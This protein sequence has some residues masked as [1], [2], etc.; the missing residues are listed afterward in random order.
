M[1]KTNRITF[2]VLLCLSMVGC[3]KEFS[4]SSKYNRP[5]WLAGKI[6]TQIKDQPEFSTFAKCLEITGFDTIIN[7]S[8]SYTVFAPNNTA[9]DTYLKSNQYSSVEDIPVSFLTKIVKYMIVQDS[10][11]K[12]QLESLDVYGWIDSTDLNNNKPRG[13]KR[14]T[15]L[16]EPNQKY[17]VT[18]KKNNNISIVDSANGDWYRMVFNNTRKYVPIFFKKYLD[19]SNLTKA[20]Y[21]F[22]F[23]RP[24]ESDDDIYFAGAKIIGNEIFA[25]NGFIYNVDRVVEPLKNAEEILNTDKDGHSYSEFLDLVHFFP[26]F[27]YNF[28]ETY[29]QPGAAEGKKVDSLFGLSY[30]ILAFDISNEQTKPPLGS[31]G[32]PQ[33]VTIRYHHGMVAPTNQAF[34]N[35]I[36]DYIKIPNGWGKLENAPQH[37]KRII[38]NT[39]MSINSVYPS[40]FERGYY[41]GE[42]DYVPVDPATVIQKEFGSNCTFIGVN[43][44]IIPRAFSSV[45]GPVYT[46]QGYSRVMYAIEN[47][48]LLSALKRKD[49]NYMFL[50]E[51]DRNLAQDSSLIYNSAFQNFF[52]FQISRGTANRFGLTTND[53]RTLL[54]NHIGS[55]LPT[56]NTRKEFI[57]NLAGNYIV[58]NNETG[59]VS[60]TDRTTIGYDGSENQPNFLKK[61]SINADNGNTY[62]ISNWLSFTESSIYSRITSNF[63]YFHNLLKKAGYDDVQNRSY[64]FLSD[65]GFYTV[66]VPTQ[67]AITAYGADTLTGQQLKDFLLLHFIQGKIIFTDGKENPGYYDTMRPDERSTEFSKVFTKIYIDPEPDK[68]LIPDKSGNN[69]LTID[70]SDSTNIIAGKQIGEGT[71]TIKNKITYGVIHQISKV[72]TRNNVNTN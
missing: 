26:E 63:P 70:E 23:D 49:A 51:S 36:N 5:D 44:A 6:Y 43:K 65:N 10:W 13:F 54:L 19:I 35:F 9:F 59:E 25:E 50:V 57:K 66:F 17:W 21:S 58:V 29:N 62:E 60:G 42:S 39:H 24:F 61:I 14:E 7:T 69:Y 31:F 53:L 27:T 4:P 11:S 46:Q 45:T 37:I 15:L 40:D 38:A 47:A 30:P 72:L 8:G 1:T 18:T 12:S 20:D 32:L 67:E 64:T 71:E 68:I 28:E 34:D 48:G 16:K 33:N 41:N 3:K 22:Y 56:G 2:V 55:A 52:L